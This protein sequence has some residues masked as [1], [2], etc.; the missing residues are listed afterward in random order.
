M[1]PQPSPSEHRSAQ[2]DR[3]AQRRARHVFDHVGYAG[4]DQ[5]RT[6]SSDMIGM[7]QTGPMLFRI[8]AVALTGWRRVDHVEAAQRYRQRVRPDELERI[9]WLRSDVD[10]DDVE[11]GARIAGCRAACAAKQIHQAHPHSPELLPL[12]DRA[13][14]TAMLPSSVASRIQSRTRRRLSA[15]GNADSVPRTT[16]SARVAGSCIA[17]LMA[18]P[19]SRLLTSI[20]AFIIAS[21]CLMPT[22]T[23]PNRR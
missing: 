18:S 9:T 15:D 4:R 17:R 8:D 19:S 3:R 10:A 11:A 12:S 22:R 13:R 21:R 5:P 14:R 7:G 6:D 20:A 16:T 2:Q 23:G 1:A